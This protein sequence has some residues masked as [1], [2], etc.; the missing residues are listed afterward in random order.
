MRPSPG[1]RRTASPAGCPAATSWG[2]RA[3]QGEPVR[4]RVDDPGRQ[5]RQG[6]HEHPDARERRLV[7]RTART[8]AVTLAAGRPVRGT[9]S[10]SASFTA[11]SRLGTVRRRWRRGIAVVDRPLM[12]ASTLGSSQWASTG[13]RA[14]A[15]RRARSRGKSIAAAAFCARTR[16]SD[17]RGEAPR[18]SSSD[19][20]VAAV[21]ATLALH[22]VRDVDLADDA[23]QLAH[24][25]GVGDGF[26]VLSG[27]DPVCEVSIAT[28]A[29]STG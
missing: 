25:R 24:L 16:C 7:S 1:E 22:R 4:L 20:R 12:A 28:S 17:A 10:T 3:D 23:D 26:E 14:G 18:V 2:D 5:Q 27:L 6:D 13:R 19:R 11:G 15:R 21:I 9:V 8:S 29:A